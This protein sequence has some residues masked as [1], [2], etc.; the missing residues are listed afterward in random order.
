MAT[1]SAIMS[2]FYK[3]GLHYEAQAGLDSWSSCPNLLITGI[4]SM[5]YH[6][7]LKFLIG[8]VNVIGYMHVYI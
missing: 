3:I 6:P 8:I 2:C 4:T 5:Y 1:G 7:W